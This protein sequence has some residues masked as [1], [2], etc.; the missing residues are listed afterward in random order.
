MRRDQQER[1]SLYLLAFDGQ[2]PRFGE[3]DIDYRFAAGAEPGGGTSKG[4][5]GPNATPAAS[6]ELPPEIQVDRY[7][8]QAERAIEREDFVGARAALDKISSLDAAPGLELPA[9]FY[10]RRA[11]VER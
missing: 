10:F 1:R 8:R 6:F 5:S 4:P 9:A 3:W 2:R 7:L 11:Q